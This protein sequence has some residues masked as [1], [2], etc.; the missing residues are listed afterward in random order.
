MAGIQLTQHFALDS[1]QSA[2]QAGRPVAAAVAVGSAAFFVI[3]VSSRRRYLSRAE[4][5]TSS[6]GR[7]QPIVLGEVS[8]GF[9][10]F[11]IFISESNKQTHD[12]SPILPQLM[13]SLE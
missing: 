5:R 12:H 13:V 8:N 1:S 11:G 10:H 3:S 4:V 7:E 2:Y 9:L 6:R